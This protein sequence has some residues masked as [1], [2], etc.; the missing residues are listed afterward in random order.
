LALKYRVTD[1]RPGSED[2][3]DVAVENVRSPE[4]A[5]RTALGLEVVR[6]G[7]KANLVARVHWERVGQLDHSVDLYR[8]PQPE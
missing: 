2:D 6:S 1:L 8:R 7:T 5:V 4:D 3:F